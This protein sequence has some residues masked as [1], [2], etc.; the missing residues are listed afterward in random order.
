M[1]HFVVNPIA[2]GGHGKRAAEEIRSMLEKQNIPAVFHE[3][4][5]QGG[6]TALAAQAADDPDCTG[7]I[8][9][10]GDGTAYEV[11][12]GLVARN[13]PMGFVACGTGNDFIKT[14]GLPK[15]PRKAMEFILNHQPRPLDVA[16]IND[17]M[18]L[19]VAGTGFDVLV[20]RKAAPFLARMN[21]LLPYMM[22]LIRA[23]C[24]YAPV[25]VEYEIDGQLF[26]KQVL[27]LA[28]CNGRI[29]GGGIPICPDADP[30]D[31]K[32]DVVI[33][34][35]V[36]KLKICRLLPALMQGKILSFAEAKRVKCDRITIRSK[37]MYMQ[38]DG[39]IE[40]IDTADIR[41]GKGGLMAWW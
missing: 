33:V 14:L 31:G 10:G 24:S 4:A 6:G 25:D 32:L 34:D 17:R 26:R 12:S 40:Q 21:G 39:E 8:A 15:E 37:G 9:V 5:C 11:A 27:I 36:S 3:T 41:V 38:L 18:Y 29:I 22:G 1:L 35:T 13:V 23:I 28:V 20:L 16:H 30:S 19:N 2:G 7:V